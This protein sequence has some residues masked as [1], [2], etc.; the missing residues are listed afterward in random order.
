MPHPLLEGSVTGLGKLLTASI[1]Q[2]SHEPNT[3]PR[4]RVPHLEYTLIQFLTFL[5]GLAL[6]AASNL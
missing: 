4:P 6:G 2:C 1:R 3:W 5:A